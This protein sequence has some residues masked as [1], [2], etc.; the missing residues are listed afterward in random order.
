M[1]NEIM[2]KTCW[3]QEFINPAQY[4]GLKLKMLRRDMLI[5]PSI[6]E[7]EHLN[8]L[9]TREAIDAA[10]HSIIDRHWD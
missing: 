1:Y 10:V 6:E 4:I 7:I 3:D 9:K 5:Y 2:E 8:T